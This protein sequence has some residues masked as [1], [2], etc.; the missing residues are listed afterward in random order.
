MPPFL[1]RFLQLQQEVDGE[2]NG[3][4]CDASLASAAPFIVG[5]GGDG[6]APG[7][8][9]EGAVREA[10]LLHRRCAAMTPVALHGIVEEGRL[11]LLPRPRTVAA[12]MGPMALHG[13]AA[14][15]KL[16]LLLLLL[17]LHVT[18]SHC[19]ALFGE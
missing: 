5:G 3:N 15:G 16:L 8:S 2:S 12:R 18:A 9:D 10:V 6:G 7:V 19:G 11:L 13:V 17:L 4:A 1:K 14:L